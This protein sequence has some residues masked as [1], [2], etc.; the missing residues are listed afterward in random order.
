[1]QQDGKELVDL[2]GSKQQ[3][4][5]PFAATGFF[6]KDNRSLPANTVSMSTTVPPHSFF[7]QEEEEEERKDILNK[8]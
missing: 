3:L 1:M 7:Q 4:E 6:Q 8:G 5:R 2:L